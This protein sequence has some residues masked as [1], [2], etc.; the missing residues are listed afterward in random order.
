MKMAPLL[1]AFAAHHP[2]I[3]TILV[4]SGQ[5]YDKDMN[6]R[7]FVDLCLPRPNINIEVGSGTHAVQTAKVMRRFE[8]VLDT[9]KPSC[10]LVVGDVNSTLAC[11][12]VSVE[13]SLPVAHVEVGLRSYDRSMPEEIN[14]VLTDQIAD[15]LYTTERSALDNLLREGIAEERARFVSNVMIDSPLASREFSHALEKTLSDAGVDMVFLGGRRDYAVVTL[16]RP[17]SVDQEESLRPLLAVLRE[18]SEKLP[19]IIVLHPR[20]RANIDRFGLNDLIVS[21]RIVL[22]P[23]QCY[24]EMLGLMSAAKLILTDSGGLQEETTALGIHCLTIRENIERPIA[25]GQGT[26]TMVGS[27][28]KAIINGVDEFLSGGGK[29]GRI[30]ELWDGQAAERIAA[31]LGQSLLALHF[32]TR[33]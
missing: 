25:V 32:Q 2:R 7:L 10:V 13:N 20:T 27:D 14:R 30:P 18:I 24:L 12:L 8:P 4:H 33:E 31:D 21:K 26:N 6:D 16:H 22:L 19:L 23:P 9:C 15:L 11:T 28:C 1:R 17:S 3:P 29:C 5:H